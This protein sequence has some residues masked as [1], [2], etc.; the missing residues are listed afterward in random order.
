MGGNYEV[1]YSTNSL[2]LIYTFFVFEKDVDVKLVNYSYSNRGNNL[3]RI[4]AILGNNQIIDLNW[5]YTTLLG[6][7]DKQISK[8][9]L[10]S[11][12]LPS[13]MIAFIKEGD[14]SLSAA[15][16]T[17]DFIKEKLSAGIVPTG[18]MGEKTIYKFD[19]VSFKAPIQR[20]GKVVAAGR[21]FYEH[22]EES[23]E[24]WKERGKH[25]ISKPPFP[26][27]FVK[28]STTIIGPY[29]P[30]IY[31]RE[32]QELD[33]EVELAIIIG[34]T[35]KNVVIDDAYDYIMGYTVFNDISARDWQ[36]NEMKNL[37][38]LLGKNFDSTAPMGPWIVT[39]DEIDDPQNLDLQLKV[40]GEIRQ[41]SNLKFMIYKIPE[42]IEH[43]S[44]MTLEPGDIITS[45]TPGGVAI[46]RKPDP[47]KWYLKPGDVVEAE[48]AGIGTIRNNIVDDN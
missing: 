7:V 34:N 6:E 44:M 23:I 8:Y 18:P 22:M 28:V 39:K 45:G 30:I 19:E 43:W 33:Y 11:R 12:R 41:N 36:I 14:V 5:A 32:T 46:A 24:G 16:E 13:D 29:D 20:P 15:V 3:N 27:G 2:H 38:I 35:A 31:P 21:N 26:L 25:D 10:A 48:I 17:I 37:F 40:N 9:F 1:L 47:R 4:G 42:L